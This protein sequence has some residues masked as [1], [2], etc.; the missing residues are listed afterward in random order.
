MLAKG[1]KMLQMHTLR[2]LNE[3][4]K[5]RDQMY[6]DRR[7]QFA[8][9]LKWSVSIDDKQREIDQ[10]DNRSAF[11][12]ICTDRDGNH[13]GSMGMSSTNENFMI[14]DHFGGDFPNMDLR[15]ASVWEVTRFCVSPELPNFAQLEIGK[16]VLRGVSHFALAEGI[17]EFVGLCYPP[18]LRIY[19][20]AGCRP[21][22]IREGTK[23][24]SLLLV[25][26]QVCAKKLSTLYGSC[27]DLGKT[28]PTEKVAA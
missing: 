18:L 22:H 1:T 24:A 14:G 17:K 25:R 3:N 15:A 7:R 13:Q 12:L 19:R 2:T 9:R 6:N 8:D 16:V 11:Y 26:W 21:D 10:Y 4:P 23:D 20:S 27:S 5:L 28:N